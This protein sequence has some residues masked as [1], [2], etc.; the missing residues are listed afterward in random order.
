[1]S[2]EETETMDAG[3]A[4]VSNAPPT[5]FEENALVQRRPLLDD[6]R[7]DVTAMVDL[8][9]MMNI[10]FLVTWVGAALSEMDLPKARHCIAA[11]RDKSV[12]VTVFKGPKFYLGD[13]EAG[14]ALTANEVDQRLQSAIEAGMRDGRN[15]VLIKAE[16]N[17]P[18][19]DIAHVATITNG[20]LGAK[21]RLAVIEKAAE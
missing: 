6:A 13:G 2:N 3:P 15:L 19:R 18:L 16:R 5:P 20:V 1:M 4:P 8:V 10:Y 12:V 7:F 14:Q 11:D 9:F 17:V 21:L